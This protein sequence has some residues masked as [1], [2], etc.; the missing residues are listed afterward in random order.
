M[1]IN[2]SATYVICAIATQGHLNESQ[3]AFVDKY[4]LQYSVSGYEWEFYKTDDEIE[5]C[6]LKYTGIPT[7]FVFV[8]YTKFQGFVNTLTKKDQ[9]LLLIVSYNGSFQNFNY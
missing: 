8:Q 5:V 6:S 3:S 2:L 9:G 1:Q 4:R 7:G